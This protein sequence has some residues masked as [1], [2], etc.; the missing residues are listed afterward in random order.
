MREEW[1]A[2]TSLYSKNTGP[3][4]SFGDGHDDTRCLKKLSSTADEGFLY[5]LL[6]T[7]APVEPLR[8]PT[9]DS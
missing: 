4:N 8:L 6:E 1:A 5:L 2:R 3:A 7:G 9:T